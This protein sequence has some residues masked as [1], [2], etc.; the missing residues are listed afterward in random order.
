M[1]GRAWGALLLAL[2]AGSANGAETIL[3]FA[4]DT[5]VSRALAGTSPTRVCHT[6]S[7]WVRVGFASLVLQGSDSLKLSG[8][9]GGV[10]TLTACDNWN[11]RSF[12]TRAL[13]GS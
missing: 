9:Q 10:V 7:R 2:A 12:Y 3:Q 4:E 1:N 5:A 13:R 11:G 6:N 8:T